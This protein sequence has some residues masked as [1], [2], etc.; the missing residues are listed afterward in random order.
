MHISSSNNGVIAIGAAAPTVVGQ[1]GVFMAGDGEF[2]FVSASS[3]NPTAWIKNDSSGFSIRGSDDNFSV[4]TAGAMSA[5][6]ASIDGDI[7]AKSGWF[8]SS[9]SGWI[10]SGDQIADFSQS[11]LLDANPE[12]PSINIVSASYA[13]TLQR[14]FTDKSTILS[15][16]GNSFSYGP[17]VTPVNDTNGEIDSG[18]IPGG[19]G[20]QTDGINYW[21]WANPTDAIHFHDTAAQATGS[22]LTVDKKYKTRVKVKARITADMDNGGYAGG[23]AEVKGTIRLKKYDGSTHTTMGTFDA[24]ATWNFEW[25]NVMTKTYSI[26][27]NH[28]THPST[29]EYWYVNVS[30]WKVLSNDIIENWNGGAPKYLQYQTPASISNIEVWTD[31]IEHLPSSKALEITPV[32]LQG[33]VLQTDTLESADTTD[34]IYDN[35]FFA[36]NPSAEYGFELLGDAAI[37]GSMVL[38]ERG[39]TDTITLNPASTTSNIEAS[40]I[41]VKSPGRLYLNNVDNNEYLF[42]NV[43]IGYSTDGDHN[44]QMGDAT[45]FGN[46]HADNDIIGFSTT[47]A[48]DKRL[49]TNIEPLTGS[50][51]KLKEL[52]PIEFDWLTG[53][54]RHEFGF[55]AQDIE[56]IIPE[57]V[58]EHEAIGSTLEFLQKL[59]GTEKYKTVD[60]SKLTVLLV[61][62]I[63]EQQ[64]QI[65]ELT[66]KI[67]EL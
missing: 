49:K 37:T 14:D 12:Q 1:V 48:S 21:T 27:L 23:T 15:T 18:T 2:S 40:Y 39:T 13:A 41:R 5:N 56:K 60:Y 35:Q 61:D 43:G 26:I 47:T 28:N 67:K 17:S 25:G 55:I 64:R 36:L 66:K 6:N 38:K 8:G 63:K 32:G 20:V 46:F 59:D 30:G 50:L 24:D 58:T 44:F 16:G 33:V 9:G 54:N 57:V 42:G 53:R 7:R 62:A 4:T 3:G 31:Q 22:I 52:R 29:T 34:G 51:S 11:I 45:D 19:G 10:I 65:D